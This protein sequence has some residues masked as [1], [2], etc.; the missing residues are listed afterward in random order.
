MKVLKQKDSE[1]KEIL[2]KSVEK[3]DIWKTY[4]ETK[5]SAVLKYNG[6]LR[7][8]SEVESGKQAV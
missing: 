7:D 5:R 3:G 8:I 4:N 6:L 1:K 2:K